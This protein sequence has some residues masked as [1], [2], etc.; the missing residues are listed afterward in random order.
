VSLQGT[1]LA[2]VSARIGVARIGAF[3]LGFAPD[4]VAGPGTVGPGEYGWQE[5]KPEDDGQGWDLMTPWSMCAPPP[6]Y[7]SGTGDPV[8]FTDTS[9]PAAEITFWHWDFGDGAES[10]E[11]NPTHA[12]AHPGTYTVRLWVASPRGSSMAVGT[13]GVPILKGTVRFDDGG[14]MDFCEGNVVEIR[15][16]LGVVQA[17]TV[18]NGAGQFVFTSPV[19]TMAHGDPWEIFVHS[20]GTCAGCADTSDNSLFWVANVTTTISILMKA[21]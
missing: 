18:T 8:L 3:R 7:P 1:D 10:D 16:A 6:D 20:P 17:T 19:V 14:G 11:Q 9:T 12:F 4:D 13:V 15:N 21:I 2:L 5:V